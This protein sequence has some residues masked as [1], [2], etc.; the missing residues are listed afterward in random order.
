MTSRLGKGKQRNIFLRCVK[1]RNH[2]FTTK[3]SLVHM[4]YNPTQ[5]LNT[6]PIEASNP[7]VIDCLQSPDKRLQRWPT[8]C[9]I[10]QH[11]FD[12]CEDWGGGGV[13]G[14]VGGGGGGMGE[15]REQRQS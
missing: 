8:G 3:P 11:I 10:S 12:K 7:E 2:T 5:I 14:G 1:R 13:E 4:V 6:T 9:S 15:V